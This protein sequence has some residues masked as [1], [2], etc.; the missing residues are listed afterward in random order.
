M[1][2]NTPLGLKNDAKYA[3][4][5]FRNCDD[6]FPN[7][8]YVVSSSPDGFAFVLGFLAPLWVVGGFDSSVHISEEARNASTAI[9]W[10]VMLST[11]ASCILGWGINVS[12]TFNM[13]KDINGIFSNAIGQPLATFSSTRHFSALEYID[14]GSVHGGHK[15]PG[16]I[17]QADFCIQSR[18]RIGFFKVNNVEEFES[19]EKTL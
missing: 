13:G 10:A 9:P 6:V 5:S 17:F 7:A 14:H 19:L 4:G 16:V 1:P 2:T 8:T 12:L 18:W 15:P 11:A 3:F